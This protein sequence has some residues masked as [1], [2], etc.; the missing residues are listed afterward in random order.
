MDEFR[1]IFGPIEAEL[2]SEDE[3]MK[4]MDA[5]SIKTLVSGKSKN[6]SDV[7]PLNTSER[8]LLDIDDEEA[9][10]PVK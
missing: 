10:N 5:K 7:T 6:N 8:E 2:S 1:K 4:K 3:D 9:K